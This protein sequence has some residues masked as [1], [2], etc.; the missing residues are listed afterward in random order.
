MFVNFSFFFGR[1]K[2]SEV[3]KF[4]TWNKMLLKKKSSS[5]D[6]DRPAIGNILVFHYKSFTHKLN[7]LLLI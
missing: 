5:F 1:S 6:K 7:L 4:I 2:K 3:I